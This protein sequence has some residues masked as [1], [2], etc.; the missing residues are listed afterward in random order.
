[1]S[2][3][4]KKVMSEN[5]KE[6]KSIILKHQNQFESIYSVRF[7]EFQKRFFF[8]NLNFSNAYFWKISTFLNNLILQ[9]WYFEFKI[10]WK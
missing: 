10:I 9:N 2:G 6:I 4:L 7:S 1:M 8:W 5:I 3:K